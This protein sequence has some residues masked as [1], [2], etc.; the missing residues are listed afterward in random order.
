MIDYI[1]KLTKM[2]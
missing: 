2:T 1:H